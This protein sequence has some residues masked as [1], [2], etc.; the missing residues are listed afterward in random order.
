MNSRLQLRAWRAES[1]ASCVTRLHVR[2]LGLRAGVGLRIAPPAPD[3]APR[4]G[5]LA[6]L[7]VVRGYSPRAGQPTPGRSCAADPPSSPSWRESPR[8]RPTGNTAGT[9]APAGSVWCPSSPADT[10]RIAVGVSRTAGEQKAPIPIA[11]I[12]CASHVALESLMGVVAGDN[13]DLPH[14]I[15]G[16][17]GRERRGDIAGVDGVTPVVLGHH[18]PEIERS[19]LP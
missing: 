1:G 8:R 17:C 10:S 2:R 14:G 4:I 5:I 3:E 9:T 7:L 15:G 6:G 16:D 18:R 12:L 11:T 19:K 13:E